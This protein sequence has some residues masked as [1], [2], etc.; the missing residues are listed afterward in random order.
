MMAIGPAAALGAGSFGLSSLISYGLNSAAASRAH[1]RQKN[2][3]TRM[4]D[5]LRAAGINPIYAY[6]PGAKPPNAAIAQA[7]PAQM[8]MGPVAGAKAGAEAIREARTT[9]AAVRNARLQGDLLD[10]QRQESITRS[11]LNA[12]QTTL[13]GARQV[14]EQRKTLGQ[15]LANQMMGYRRDRDRIRWKADMSPLGQGAIRAGTFSERILKPIQDAATLIPIPGYRPT[16][17]RSTDDFD[18]HF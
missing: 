18:R 3:I 4:P 15:E 13:N 5:Y 8:G 9:N 6:S 7:A 14:L 2:M 10:Q 12:S 1:D 16:S 17:A 11:V